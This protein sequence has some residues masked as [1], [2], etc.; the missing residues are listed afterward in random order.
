MLKALEIRQF[1]VQEIF[2]LSHCHYC[3]TMILT[4]T[5]PLHKGENI[6]FISR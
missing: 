5:L 3:L 1:I 4:K 2:L 6:G